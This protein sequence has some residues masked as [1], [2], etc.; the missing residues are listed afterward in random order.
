MINCRYCHRPT[1]KVQRNNWSTINWQCDYHGGVM[2]RYLVSESLAAISHGE[3]LATTIFVCKWKEETYHV[4]FVYDLKDPI[5]F[6]IDKV[7]PAKYN[8]PEA[9]E[10]I[11]TLTFLPTDITPENV[12]NKLPTYLLFS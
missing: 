8:M 3:I 2:V 1:R 6:R 12:M 11:V 7:L 9:T 5:K 4:V 10:P